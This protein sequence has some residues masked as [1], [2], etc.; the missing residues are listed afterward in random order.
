MLWVCISS[1]DWYLLNLVTGSWADDRGSLSHWYIN[2]LL[3]QNLLALLEKGGNIQSWG[4]SEE[5]TSFY[6]WFQQVFFF[7]LLVLSSVL[8]LLS[9][10][11]EVGFSLSLYL[12]METNHFTTQNPRLLFIKQ[13][14]KTGFWVELAYVINGMVCSIQGH[15]PFI[16]AK[17]SLRNK[18]VLTF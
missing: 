7:L 1:L 4:L 10:K 11:L 5:S 6:T 3:I 13:D 15:Y 12:W 14:S 8:C 17:N 9:E 16:T 2:Y 18:V